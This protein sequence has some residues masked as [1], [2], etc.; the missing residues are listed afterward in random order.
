MFPPIA[1]HE[2]IQKVSLLPFFVESF[3]IY[4][5]P[6]NIVPWDFPQRFHIESDY[7]KTALRDFLIVFLVCCSTLSGNERK[8][9]GA[10]ERE[11]VTCSSLFS[12][13]VDV[14]QVYKMILSMPF[15]QN[16]PKILSLFMVYKVCFSFSLMTQVTVS[17]KLCLACNQC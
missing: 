5:N 6:H 10:G 3:I 16:V 14:A 12:W 4:D 7:V 13:I 11:D 1:E 8:R 9:R 15:H 2:L 17:F